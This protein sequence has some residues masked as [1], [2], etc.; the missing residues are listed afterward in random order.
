V[1]GAMNELGGIRRAPAGSDTNVRA[2]GRSRAPTPRPVKPDAVEALIAVAPLVSRWIDRV[3]AA[4]EPPLT[5]TQFL[6]LRAI[7]A[8]EVSGTEIARRTGVS[9]PTV[10]QP[11]S[12]LAD[13]GLLERRELSEDRRGQTLT[14]RRGGAGP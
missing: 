11:P 8:G 10:S 9:G 2:S 3:L 13:A 5:P 6:A 1:V 14:L 7:A 12:S 4:H